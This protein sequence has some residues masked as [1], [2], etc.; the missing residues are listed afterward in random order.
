LGLLDGIPFYYVGHTDIVLYHPILNRYKVLEIKTT[1]RK[2]V[3]D[4]MYKNSDQAIGY[5]IVL[6]SIARDQESTGTFDVM[7]LVFMTVQDLWKNFD[8]SKSRSMRA[9]WINTILLDIQRINTYRRAGIW[10]KRGGSCMDFGRP[11]QFFDICDMGP[12]HFNGTGEFDI[13]TEEELAENHF[14]FRFSLQ[15]IINTQMELV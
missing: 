15:D 8:Y 2:F 5:S 11:C 12:E 14:D 4:A 7:Y 1:G 6:D 3:H 13:I 10:P 9:E